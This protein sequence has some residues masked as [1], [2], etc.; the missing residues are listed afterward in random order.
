MKIAIV[1]AGFADLSSARYRLRPRR[2]RVRRRRT[3]AASGAAHPP[4]LRG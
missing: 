4:P 2:R 3:W 1:G